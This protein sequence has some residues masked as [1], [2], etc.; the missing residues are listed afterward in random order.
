[1]V[2]FIIM[3]VGGG[4][5][6]LGLAFMLLPGTLLLAM[7]G[8][9]DD[10][11]NVPCQWRLLLSLLAAAIC[12]PPLGVFSDLILNKDLILPLG[13]I[14]NLLAIIAIIWSTNLFNFMDGLDGIA[15]MEAI[16]ILGVGGYLIAQSDGGVMAV[17]C[18]ALA[19]CILGFLVW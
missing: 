15:G 2:A 1:W 3:A 6:A 18:W 7:T 19:A 16:F 12:V 14:G 8:C 13:F 4:I 17:L 9:V 11:F 5:L 10:R